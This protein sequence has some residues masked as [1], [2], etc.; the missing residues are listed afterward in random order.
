MT[1]SHT[2]PIAMVRRAPVRITITLPHRTYTELNSTSHGEGRS[3][4]NLSAYLLEWAL[5]ERDRKPELPPIEPSR[6][7]LNRLTLPA[8]RYRVP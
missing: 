5:R 2:E 3:V 7:V 6:L 4:S 1:Q 8:N